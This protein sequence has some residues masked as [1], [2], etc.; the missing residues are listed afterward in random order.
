[1][2][3]HSYTVKRPHTLRRKRFLKKTFFAL[4]LVFGITGG[5]LYYLLH[6]PLF[7]VDTVEIRGIQNTADI[8]NIAD[9]YL[10]T[11]NVLGIAR[12]NYFFASPRDLRGMI[13]NSFP[14][15]ASVDVFK[16]F[17]HRIALAVRERQYAEIGRAHV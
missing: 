6:S 1:M 5:G 8:R 17:P 12:N 7:I 14:A 16:K 11:K 13:K 9:R 15:L 2:A 3:Y 4:F 10:G